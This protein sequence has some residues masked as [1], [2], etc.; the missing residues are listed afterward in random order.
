MVPSPQERA[1]ISKEMEK[2][3]MASKTFGFDM[4]IQDRETKMSGKLHFV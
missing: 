4:A 1:K 3:R 2:Y